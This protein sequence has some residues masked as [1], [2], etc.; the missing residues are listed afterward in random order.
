FAR[1]VVSTQLAGIPELVANGE[2]GLLVPPANNGALVEALERLMRN[3]DLRIAYGQAARSRVEQHFR[4]DQTIAPLVQ[5]LQ[6][7]CSRRPAGDAHASPRDAATVAA[8]AAGEIA[9]LIDRWPDGELPM[10]DREIEEMRNRN[11]PILPI[12]CEF[13]ATTR[14]TSA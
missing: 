12:V 8:T 5:L 2:T 6:K 14:L 10:L 1:P 7:T 3:S 4:I 11:V 9:Y 13:D